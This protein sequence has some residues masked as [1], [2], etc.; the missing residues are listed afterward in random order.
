MACSMYYK[1]LSRFRT[2]Y[3]NSQ[4]YCMTFEDLLSL[5]RQ[6]LRVTMGFLG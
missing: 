2:F 6:A 1:Q 3:P 5:P 4:I